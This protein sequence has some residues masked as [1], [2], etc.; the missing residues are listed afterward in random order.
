MRSFASIDRQRQNRERLSGLRILNQN[1]RESTPGAEVRAITAWIA[2]RRCFL[3]L[4][5]ASLCMIAGVTIPYPVLSQSAESGR[6][7]SSAPPEVTIYL[8]VGHPAYGTIEQLRSAGL[9][10]DV[11]LNQR[12]L[13]R[14]I[15]ARALLEGSRRAHERGLTMLA[16]TARWRLREFSR[17]LE[18]D[19]I[20][21]DPGESL[22]TLHWEGNHQTSITAEPTVE[23]AY[24]ARKDIPPDHA[25]AVIARWG[26]ELY[27]TAGRG[28]GYTARYRESFENRK[29][30]ARQ[31]KHAPDQT[32]YS[33]GL[34]GFGEK[35]GYSESNSHLSWDGSV[36]GADLRFDSP[37]WGPSPGANLLLA[38]HAASFGHL[39]F[40]ARFGEW[41]HYTMLAGSLA[42]GLTDSLRSYIPD[43]EAAYRTLKRRKYLIGHRLDLRVA[44]N[45]VIGLTEAVTGGD[46]SPELIYFVPTASIWDSQHY[47]D[48]PDNM[49][50]SVD[51]S[52]SIPEG[53]HLYGTIGIDEWLLPETFSDKSQ[54]WIAVQLGG[55]WTLPIHE[56]RWHLWVEATRVQPNVYRHKYPVNDWTHAGSGLGFWSGQ[57][58]EVIEGR[59]TFLAS[60]RMSVTA[61]GRYARKGGEGSRLLQYQNPP[62]ERFMD[63]ADRHGAWVAGRLVYE[64]KQHWRIVA[65]IVRAPELLWPHESPPASLGQAWQYSIRWIYNPF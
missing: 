54:N 55:S 61:W 62:A 63:G 52:W 44:S 42:S 24:D 16:E 27:G 56:G 51:A 35:L 58:S 5:A 10:T 37:S 11:R 64:G 2:G 50:V 31:W 1:N 38:G 3:L 14:L 12:P 7:T 57:N 59:L 23:F 20:Q 13:S 65:E 46:R 18:S 26:F 60:S 33:S 28:I 30:S 39:Q 21:I 9:I 25:S 45:L 48:D 4:V 32:V 34:A 43:G 36:F 49:M 8:P 29:R 6:E 40:R 17:D 53:P 19:G 15:V 41:L 22:L 47:L